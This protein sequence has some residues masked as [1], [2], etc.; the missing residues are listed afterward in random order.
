MNFNLS[1]ETLNVIQNYIINIVRDE[2]RK[3]LASKNIEEF[4]NFKIINVQKSEDGES[5]ISA[6]VQDMITGQATENI[7]NESGK[8]L[9]VGDI[10][11]VY[12]TNSD[13]HNRYIGRNL[14]A[15]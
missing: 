7:P 4:D 5:V 9:D 11:R 14:G 6:T 1:E 10:V 3:I 15:K 8:N 12:G 13:N 2:V